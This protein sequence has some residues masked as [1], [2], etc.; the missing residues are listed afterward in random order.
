MLGIRIPYD[1]Y[2]DHYKSY[3]CTN[4]FDFRFVLTHACRPVGTVQQSVEII[5]RLLTT[6]ILA[7]SGCTMSGYINVYLYKIKAMCTIMPVQG[8]VYII[9]FYLWG[10]MCISQVI[11]FTFTWELFFSTLCQGHAVQDRATIVFDNQLH[12]NL[13]FNIYI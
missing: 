5:V 10:Q 12:L 1:H 11:L 9:F 8:Q 6:Y 13:L 7:Y 4:N 2:N 3:I